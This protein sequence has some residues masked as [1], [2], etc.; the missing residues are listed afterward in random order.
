[1]IE[2]NP[3]LE[4][5]GRSMS[6]TGRRLPGQVSWILGFCVLLT[7]CGSGDGTPNGGQQPSADQVSVD[8]SIL[9]L[10]A[11]YF[12][13]I[14][15]ATGTA[16]KPGQI[17]EFW[18]KTYPMTGLPGSYHDPAAFNVYKTGELPPVPCDVGNDPKRWANNALYCATDESLSWHDIFLFGS[19][20]NIGHFA[21][22]AVLG[23]EWGHHIQH[24]GGSKATRVQA[25]LQADCYAGLFT[26]YAEEQG[27]L[28]AGDFRAAFA[29]F[30]LLGDKEY[31]RE[32][33]F[34][35][36]V[37]GSPRLRGLAFALGDAAHEPA[38]CVAYDDYEYADP[39]VFGRYFVDAWP[40]VSITRDGEH[41]VTLSRGKGTVTIT[42]IG[43]LAST[44]S[45]A[46]LGFMSDDWAAGKGV[47][48]VDNPG[49]AGVAPVVG[50]DAATIRYERASAA[51]DTRHGALLLNVLAD[52]EALLVDASVPGPG[53]GSSDIAGWDPLADVLYSTMMGVCSTDADSALCSPDFR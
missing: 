9:V 13:A 40:G 12:D 16:G 47:R 23:H 20:M 43:R 2:S 41:Q 49:D 30:M 33:W 21:P 4:A 17:G 37:H 48:W 10:G 15:A 36:N 45:I 7:A 19:Y 50:G 3:S 27:I 28:A 25:E 24:L 8:P 53:P 52:G 51:G 34:D 11:G 22:I 5:W 39:I 35:P 44:D 46:E 32:H 31:G 26:N 6:A 1:M 18:A 29:Q 38:Y 14:D 42:W